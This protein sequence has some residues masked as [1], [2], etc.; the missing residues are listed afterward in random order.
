MGQT[1]ERPVLS[2]NCK[3]SFLNPSQKTRLDSLE[4]LRETRVQ[5][6]THTIGGVIRHRLDATCSRE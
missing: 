6:L 3:D 1:G 5:A 2:R 4:T